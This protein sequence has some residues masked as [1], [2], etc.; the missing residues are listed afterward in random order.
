MEIIETGES[1]DLVVNIPECCRKGL[2]DCPHVMDRDVKSKKTN[3]G[4]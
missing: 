3:I 2:P 1:K 4:L